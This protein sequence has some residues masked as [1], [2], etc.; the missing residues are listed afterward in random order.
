MHKLF[1]YRGVILFPW[2]ANIFDKNDDSTTTESDGIAYDKLATD[3]LERNSPPERTKAVKKLTYYQV[4]IDTRDIPY[5]RS[6]PESITFLSGPPSNRTVH[7]IY[8]LDF[9]SQ[10]DVLPYSSTDKVP[11]IHD[12]FDRFLKTEP[13]SSI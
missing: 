1:G 5:I 6:M 13:N 10:N 9:V 8:G 4:L 7:T 2:S 11:I 12:L 3:E